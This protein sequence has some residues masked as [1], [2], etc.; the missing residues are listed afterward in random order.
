MPPT[1]NKARAV[2]ASHANASPIHRSQEGDSCATAVSAFELRTSLR[3]DVVAPRLESALSLATAAATSARVGWPACGASAA[4]VALA[5]GVALVSVAAL[6][7]VVAAAR[8]SAPVRSA[9]TPIAMGAPARVLR[10]RASSTECT[11]ELLL[12]VPRFELG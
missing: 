5:C 7:R 9:F 2:P 4:G 10:R 3:V 12:D 1:H 6:A 11:G 8:A